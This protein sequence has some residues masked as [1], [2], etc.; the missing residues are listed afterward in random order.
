M[1]GGFV[2][3]QSAVFVAIPSTRPW[4]ELSPIGAPKR[5]NG[6]ADIGDL[7]R[8]VLN[9]LAERIVLVKD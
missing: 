1:V 8:K 7:C 6:Q 2:S 9:N 4:K 5:P 3:P